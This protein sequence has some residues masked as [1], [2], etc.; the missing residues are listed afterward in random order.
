MTVSLK[1]DK[2]IVLDSSKDFSITLIN[3]LTLSFARFKNPAIPIN[4]PIEIN[5]IEGI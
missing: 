3:V 4:K 1:L 5:P 2:F